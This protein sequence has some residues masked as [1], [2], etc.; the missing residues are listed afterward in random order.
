MAP[1]ISDDT[2]LELANNEGSLLL[3]S[4]KD[5]GDLVFRLRRLSAGVVLIRLAGLTPAKKAN[6]TFFIGLYPGIGDEELSVIGRTF[7][8][9]MSAKR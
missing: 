6:N 2:V 9:F 7:S 3:T 8:Q 1:G 4:D 5:F